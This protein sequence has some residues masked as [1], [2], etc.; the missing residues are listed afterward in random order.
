[1]EDTV[2]MYPECYAYYLEPLKYDFRAMRD[3]TDVSLVQLRE[4][5]AEAIAPALDT[6]AKRNFLK[7]LRE[8]CFNKLAICQ[9]IENSCT[10]AK[11]TR[12]VHYF[13]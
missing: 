2:I 11:R 3:N 4:T 10:A 1:M 8:E 12:M 6:R 5:V 9:L 7:R 13:A